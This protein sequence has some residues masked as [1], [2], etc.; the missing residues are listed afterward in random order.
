M[1]TALIH[2]PGLAHQVCLALRERIVSGFF[3]P[4]A[5][6]PTELKL[7]QSYGVS[8]SVIREA[9]ARLKS[10]GL[11]ESRQGSGMFAKPQARLRPLRLEAAPDTSLQAV[12]QVIELRRSV[13]AEAAAIAAERASATEIKR[14]AHALRA[15]DDAVDAGDDGVDL[16]IAFHRAIA[17]ATANPLYVQVIDFLGQYIRSATQVARANEAQRR[18]LT[19]QVRREHAAILY[20]I[21]AHDAAA[22]RR[23]AAAHLCNSAKRI[24]SADA[25]F[26]DANTRK[27]GF[28]A[29]NSRAVMALRRKS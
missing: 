20:A 7:A 11:V 28:E 6:L 13:E 18:T 21:E 4:G 8:R 23:S 17:V 15:L 5:K 26:W 24:L 14:I 9:V 2:P 22:A 12:L 29:L 19:L 25:S 1:S 10:E 27:G 16:D 3:K